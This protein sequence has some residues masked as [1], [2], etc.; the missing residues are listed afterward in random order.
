MVYSTLP[1]DYYFIG[2]EPALTYAYS[3]GPSFP[4]DP[5]AG[6]MDNLFNQMVDGGACVDNSYA[7]PQL[8]NVGIDEN[9]W[10]AYDDINSMNDVVY[11]NE[12]MDAAV[13]N[14]INPALPLTYD[15]SPL[16]PVFNDTTGADLSLSNFQFDF[17]APNT[18]GFDWNATASPRSNDVNGLANWELPAGSHFNEPAVNV[19]NYYELVS[20]VFEYPASDAPTYMR[21]G[22]TGTVP[23]GTISPDMMLHCGYLEDIPAAAESEDYPVLVQSNSKIGPVP[24][25]SKDSPSEL[26]P[27]DLFDSDADVPLDGDTGDL[28]WDTI[29][30]SDDEP[31]SKAKSKASPKSKA[32]SKRKAFPNS[33]TAPSQ[34]RARSVS[35]NNT[36]KIISLEDLTEGGKHLVPSTFHPAELL[37]FNPQK[38]TGKAANPAK[39]YKV[40]NGEEIVQYIRYKP[41]DPFSGFT[42]TKEGYLNEGIK[43]N[44][45]N[46]ER[47]IGAH[48][49]GKNL[50]FRL[51]KTPAGMTERIGFNHACR[52]ENCLEGKFKYGHFK[53]AIEEVWGRIPRR[54]R[55]NCDPYHAAGYFH[56]NCFESIVDIGQLLRFSMLRAFPRVELAKEFQTSKTDPNRFCLTNALHSHFKEFAQ[57]CILEPNWNGYKTNVLDMLSIRIWH[58]HARSGPISFS[59]RPAQLPRPDAEKLHARKKQDRGWGG[60]RIAGVSTAQA[61]T[62]ISK[63]AALHNFGYARN[64]AVMSDFANDTD[65]KLDEFSDGEDWFQ[66]VSVVHISLKGS[67]ADA[68][69]AKRAKT[70]TSPQKFKSRRGRRRY[71]S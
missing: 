15:H 53:I 1:S 50:L 12:P 49:L 43:F 3:D 22:G 63:G 57:K 65:S 37:G 31:V 41:L 25:D 17:I 39:R 62:L 71:N 4:L 29:A 14:N 70:T 28:D 46:L 54:D 48:P 13:Y 36:E 33:I 69:A 66:E 55:D 56:V 32:P 67:P 2:D 24:S 30:V 20:N 23:N 58:R 44:A 18:V 42:Y 7:N 59:L 11:S 64:A 51:E 16:T 10:P 27:D 61:D 40:N 21:D 52:A 9:T 45:A 34:K 68:P 8:P 5:H 6:H 47:F 60:Q 26:E 35:D 19:N 38:Y